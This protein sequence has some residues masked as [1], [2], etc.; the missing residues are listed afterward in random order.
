MAYVELGDFAGVGVVG[1]PPEEDSPDELAGEGAG[2]ALGAPFPVPAA[3]FASPD[4]VFGS[5]L[6]LLSPVSPED[7]G[8]ILSE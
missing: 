2:V 8:F 7:G 6:A 4:D 3:G 1:E 5:A